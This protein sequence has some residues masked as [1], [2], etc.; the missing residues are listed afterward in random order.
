[1]LPRG[2]I[3]VAFDD[4]TFAYPDGPPVLRDVTLRHRLRHPGGDR[5]GDR[6]G[7][8][9]VRQAAHPADGPRRGLRCCS[10]AS[11]SATSTRT[12]CAAAW[13]WCRRRASSSTTRWRANV[14]L[15][16]ARG[17]RGRHPRR[18]DELGLGDWVDGLPAGLRH[19]GRAAR[20][21]PVGRRAAAG[22]AAARPP[23]RPRPA[24]A[25]RGHQCGRPRPGDAHRAR[26][27]AAHAAGAPRSPSRT[28]F[29]RRER[30]RGGRRRP[31]TDR[32]ARPAPRAGRATRA[33][34]P[35]CTPR[36]WPSRARDPDA[37]RRW[38]MAR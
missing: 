1:M 4:V 33:S 35:A 34:T 3:D 15:R 6:L 19:Q 21:V 22:R 17:H 18:A 32:P 5:G 31:R 9:H 11:T 38:I 29:H 12:P 37:H 25:R 27:R 2:P 20:R 28:A 24:G 30:R 16:P 14:A 26:P 8:V 23:G 10:T 13:C 36:G 7:Q